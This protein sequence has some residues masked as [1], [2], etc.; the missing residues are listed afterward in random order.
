VVP[1]SSG[2]AVVNKKGELI[3][4]IRGRVGFAF[5]PDYTFKDHSGEIHIEVPKSQHKD[6]CAAVP[7]KKV[8]DVSRDLKKYG[9][10]RRGWLGVSM[11]FRDGKVKILQVVKNSPAE[12]AGLCKGDI[13]TKING[14]T[15]KTIKDVVNIVR[16]FK[17]EQKVKMKLTRENTPQ[18]ALVVIGELKEGKR[19]VARAYRSSSNRG[20]NTLFPEFI[21]TLPELENFVYRIGGSRILGVDVT[22][23][24][25]ELAKEFSIGEGT[26][27]M[28]T[29]VYKATAAEK[30]GFRPADII[31]KVGNQLIKS[32]S[33][34]RIILDELED[35][36]A[37]VI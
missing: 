18:S 35:N 8:V 24:T 3:G 36:E 23:L 2:G 16:S 29:R 12:K 4:V 7:V 26:G 19:R 30:A 10:V 9:K 25:P 1:G 22:T 27:L 33:D 31:V 32:N 5:S 37:V 28:I 20:V 11:D 21:E 34:L 14:K 17:P 15:I 13:I 6:L